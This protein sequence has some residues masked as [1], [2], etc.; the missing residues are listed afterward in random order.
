MDQQS[1]EFELFI[2]KAF[3]RQTLPPSEKVLRKL[4]TRL[5]LSDFLSLN[6]R[7]L[8]IMYTAIFLGGVAGI[9]SLY[10]SNNNLLKNNK[11]TFV[12]AKAEA[13][14]DQPA[15]IEKSKEEIAPPSSI[16]EVKKPEANFSALFSTS[17]KNGC[18][19]LTVQFSNHSAAGTSW[20]WNFGTGD[21]SN[22]QNPAYTYSKAGHYTATLTIFNGSGLQDSYKQQINVYEKPVADFNIDINNSD[23]SNKSLVFINQSEGG[24]SYCWDFGD[25][26]PLVCNKSTHTYADFGIYQ[27]KLIA[28]ATN[29]CVDTAMLVNKFI[30]KNYELSFPFNFWPNPID[31]NNGYYD[32]AGIES[33]VFYPRNYG[34]EKYE[35]NIYSPSGLKVFTSN[36]IK[37]GWNGYIGVQLAPGGMYSWTARGIYPNGKSFQLQGAVKVILQEFD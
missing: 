7:K 14:S 27:V 23:I 34:A 15:D 13:I 9:I 6:P 4:K 29:G 35:L 26:E 25:G 33:S 32:Q 19:P 1:Q 8:N 21:R 2:R 16:I 30:E 22:K 24:M 3:D 28:K 11:E 18:T 20:Q 10:S 31:R 17:E 37:Q 36:N 5:W 12:P